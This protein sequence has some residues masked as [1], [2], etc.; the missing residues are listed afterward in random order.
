GLGIRL[1]AL[2]TS[3]GLFQKTF[4][5]IPKFLSNPRISRRLSIRRRCPYWFLSQTL[6]HLRTTAP[7]FEFLGLTLKTLIH[8]PILFTLRS[9]LLINIPILAR[10]ATLKPFL[11]RRLRIVLRF[12]ATELGA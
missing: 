11:L 12:V 4:H 5:S 8:F 9:F 6:N 10:K 7:V 1:N 3:I 2:R